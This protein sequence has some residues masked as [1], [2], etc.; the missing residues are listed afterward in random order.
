MKIEISTHLYL[1][2]LIHN[3]FTNQTPKSKYKFIIYNYLYVYPFISVLMMYLYN[4]YALGEFC[5]LTNTIVFIFTFYLF[6]NTSLKYFSFNDS[7]H[8]FYL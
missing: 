3:I 6:Q 5:K 4:I 1:L 8:Q 7:K 2:K